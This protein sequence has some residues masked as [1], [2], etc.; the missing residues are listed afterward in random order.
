MADPQI[1]TRRRDQATRALLRVDHLDGVQVVLGARRDNGA[2]D[3]ALESFELVREFD[4]C[5]LFDADSGHADSSTERSRASGRRLVYGGRKREPP[6]L[7][8]HMFAMHDRREDAA[9]IALIRRGDRPWHHY[10]QLA[11]SAGSA[12]AILEG[13]YVDPDED[14]P[15]VLFSA[16]SRPETVDLDA[17]CT[18]IEA[19]EAEGMRF[20]T[21]LADD[22][23]VNLRSI[24]NRPPFLFVRGELR[25]E[26]ERSIAVVGTRRPSAAGVH[27]ARSV[28][29]GLVS[30]GYT[31]VSGLAEGI[32]G[33]AHKTALDL[34]GRTIAVVGTGLR[35]TYPA[36][37]A[38]LERRIAGSGAV[39]SQFWP[40]AP[41]TKTSFP[42]RNITMSGL[43]LAT[44]VIEASARSGARMQAR[45]ALEHGR[46]VFLHRSLLEHA[47][48]RDYADRPGAAVVDSADEVVEQ[49][50]RLVAPELALTF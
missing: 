15:L 36:S 21:V 42:M 45:L 35:R 33:A 2:D 29:A 19:W 20:V 34:G 31:I 48:A 1:T 30:A 9:L 47:W 44:V 23:P 49:I 6:H 50:E 13:R 17:I 26:D 24:H 7:I 25:G 22:Y 11:E 27:T 41:P 5:E 46:R 28:T 32:D 4:D 14:E 10:A 16:E 37:H 3:P 43:A 8:E 18:E 39:V 38:A 40:D 12:L